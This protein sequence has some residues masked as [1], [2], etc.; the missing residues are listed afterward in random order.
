MNPATQYWKDLA[1]LWKARWAKDQEWLAARVVEAS[2]G[3]VIPVRVTC[4]YCGVIGD[5]LV[6]LAHAPTHF[7]IDCD[8]CYKTMRVMITPASYTEDEW[9]KTFDAVVAEDGRMS[10]RSK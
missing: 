1:Q 4:P 7:K 9:Q 3:K 5:T 6:D 10:W 8:E 2:E